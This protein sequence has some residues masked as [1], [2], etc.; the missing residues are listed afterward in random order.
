MSYKHDKKIISFS[1]APNAYPSEEYEN[2]K[3]SRS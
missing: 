1:P 2:F 3:L